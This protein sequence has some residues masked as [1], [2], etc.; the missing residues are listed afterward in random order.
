MVEPTGEESEARERLAEE[1]QGETTDEW[2]KWRIS[3]VPEREVTGVVK[4][5]QLVPVKA[6]LLIDNFVKSQFGDSKACD[7]K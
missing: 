3:D 6:V 2:S 5:R 7:Q 4:S 1:S